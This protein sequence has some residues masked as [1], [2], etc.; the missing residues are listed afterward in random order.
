VPAAGLAALALTAGLVAWA[1]W[2]EPRRLVVR[3]PTLR[4]PGWPRSLDGL[5]VALV[6]DLHTGSPQVDEA[7]VARVTARVRRAR[8]DLVLLLGDYVDPHGTLAQPVTPEAVAAALAP[9]G[10]VAVLGNHDWV[11]GGPRVAGALRDAGIT[12]LEDDALGVSV[13]GKRLWLAGLADLRRRS[14]DVDAALAGVPE[15]EPLI[16]LAHD[17][18]LF[19]QI[20]PRVVLTV[21]GHTHG[22]Q[23]N[24]PG[25]RA[26]MIPSRYGDRY[27]RGHVVEGGRHL[28]VTSGVG[29]STHPVRFARPPEVVVLELRS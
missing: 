5:R 9:L 13:R 7:F 2:I 1:A 21:S 29:T 12:V 15:G 8:P 14:P 22:G 11:T 25:L 26:R 3:R 23:V 27:A 16:V 28:Y 17:P 6:S 10:G 18:D 19:P 20:P 4:L 24:L